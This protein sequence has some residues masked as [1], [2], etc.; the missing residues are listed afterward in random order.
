MKDDKGI[1]RNPFS[2]LCGWS[3]CF[4]HR[5]VQLRHRFRYLIINCVDRIPFRSGIRKLIAQLPELLDLVQSL[6]E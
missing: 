2:S 4:R 5:L 1:A 6:Y 3:V